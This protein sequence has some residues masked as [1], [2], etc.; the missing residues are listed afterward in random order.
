MM[1]KWELSFCAVE[2]EGNA[3]K[4]QITQEQQSIEQLFKYFGGKYY[5]FRSMLPNFGYDLFKRAMRD[6]VVMV[7]SQ[8]MEQFKAFFNAIQ[9]L[10]GGRRTE[11]MDTWPRELEYRSTRVC[12]SCAR[13]NDDDASFC[14]FCG[15]KLS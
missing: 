6:K 8:R 9:S 2:I 7:D 15:T 13:K 1:L 12:P 5:K 3:L 10:E 11:S 4:V 14:K